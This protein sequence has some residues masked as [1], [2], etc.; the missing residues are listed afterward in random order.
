MEFLNS[1]IINY[2][3]M[4]HVFYIMLSVAL[5]FIL[6]FNFVNEST[7]KKRWLLIVLWIMACAFYV[8]NFINQICNAESISLL[9]YIPFNISAI[10]LIIVPFMIFKGSDIAKAFLCNIVFPIT[11]INLFFFSYNLVGLNF[12]DWKVIYYFGINFFIMCLCGLPLL[13]KDF[14]P[15]KKLLW[16]SIIS[17][18]G[19]SIIAFLLNEFFILINV[20]SDVNYLYTMEYG[21]NGL[22]KVFYTLIPIK[23][24]YLFPFVGVFVIFGLLYFIPS[25]I[26]AKIQKSRERDIA[27]TMG[28]IIT[29]REIYIKKNPKNVGSNSS[30]LQDKVNKQ[31]EKLIRE[32]MIREQKIREKI[33][34]EK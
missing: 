4:M 27:M 8:S 6:Y 16:S 14:I 10:S 9:K 3:S 15:T 32:N 1:S 33:K 20:N 18:V 17:I 13:F 26:R 30:K 12:L 28:G 21:G 5:F 31:N 2:Y 19:L 7:S 11:I 29:G 23:L 34:K 22:V 24:I 25:I